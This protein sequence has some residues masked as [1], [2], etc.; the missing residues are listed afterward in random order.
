MLTARMGSGEGH[1][2]T[3]TIEYL[4]TSGRP[5][6]QTTMMNTVSDLHDGFS[7]FIKYPEHAVIYLP[8]S[9]LLGC[10]AAFAT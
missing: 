3:S 9:S 6:L 1:S 2:K 4:I 10:P 8:T 5:E 7:G